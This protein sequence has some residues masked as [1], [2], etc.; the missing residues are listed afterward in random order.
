MPESET[1]ITKLCQESTL[2]KQNFMKQSVKVDEASVVKQELKSNEELDEFCKNNEMEFE[3]EEDKVYVYKKITFESFIIYVRTAVDAYEVV[4]GE[5]KN[6]L[7][8]NFMNDDP[9]KWSNQWAT[10]KTVVTTDCYKDNNAKVIRWLT[11]AYLSDVENIK[12]AY[13]TRFTS[14][15]PKKHKILGVENT[16]VKNLS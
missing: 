1:V 11:E 2:I 6:V 5:K 12:I 8:R 13:T 16:N 15:T 10:A 3:L 7:L 4:K 14:Q 9:V